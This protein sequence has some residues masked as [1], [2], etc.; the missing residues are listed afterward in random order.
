L[1]LYVSIEVIVHISVYVMKGFQSSRRLYDG[2]KLVG[3]AIR[4]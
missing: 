2:L 3:T 4:L 1:T